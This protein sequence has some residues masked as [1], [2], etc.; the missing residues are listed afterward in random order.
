MNNTDNKEK[1]TDKPPARDPR[2][3][4]INNYNERMKQIKDKKKDDNATEKALLLGMIEKHTIKPDGDAGGVVVQTSGRP[5][6]YPTVESLADKYTEYLYYIYDKNT[7]EGADLIPDIIGFCAFADIS[8]ETLIEWEKTRPYAYSDLIKRIKT[9]ILSYKTQLGF[10]GKIPPI[11]LA[12][13]LNNNHGYT[14]NNRTDSNININIQEL[15]AAEIVQNR[16]IDQQSNG[17]GAG[18]LSDIL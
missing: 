16:V 6:K 1:K 11:V 8:R 10:K 7:N 15:P 9:E 2:G 14:Q 5:P 13:D 12:M 3:V 4:R 17:A 18:G